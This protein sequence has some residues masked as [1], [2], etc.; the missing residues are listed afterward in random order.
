MKNKRIMLITGTRKGIGKFL[1]QYYSKKG[2]VIIGCSRKPIDYK[3]PGTYHHFCLDV[4]EEIKV[5]EMFSFIRKK[6]DKLDILINN[7]GVGSMNHSLLI[8]IDTVRK[9]LNTNVLGTFLLSR[10]AAKIMKSNH[11]GKIIN[12]TSIATVLK[13]EG[14]AVYAAS[15]AAIEKLTEIL[16]REYADYGIT[17]NAIAP[18]PVKTDL[19]K[20]V[21]K[22]KLDKFLERQSIHRFSTPDDIVKII[23]FFITKENDMITGQIIYM[24]GV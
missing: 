24:G 16:S 9:I 3:V 15:K 23:N 21:P 12:F 14:E 10:E 5:K 17:V 6:Y 2:Y 20:A 7:A 1:V 11:S 13:L 22:E 19:I 8:P 18:T 4:S